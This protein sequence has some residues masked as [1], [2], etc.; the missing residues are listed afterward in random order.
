MIRILYILFASILFASCDHKEL[1]YDHSHIM[2]VD[3]TFDWSETPEASPKSMSLYLFP[4][5]DKEV[6][7]YEFTR[8]E[9][10]KIRIVPGTYRAICLNSDTENIRIQ[11]NHGFESFRLTTKDMEMLAGMTSLGVRSEDVPKIKGTEDER[12]A[13]SPD[14]IWTGSLYEMVLDSPDQTMTLTMQKRFSAFNIEVRNAENLQY[15]YAVS[16][17]L[18]TLSESLYPGEGVLSDSDVTIPFEMTADSK[19]GFIKGDFLTF[20]HCPAEDK[21]HYMTIYAIMSDGSKVYFTFDVTEQIHSSPD[22]S[23]IVIVLDGLQLPEPNLGEGGG[24]GG[25]RPEVN[26]WNQID[27]G[28]DM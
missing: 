15:A 9:G 18:T 26:G 28:I 22:D 10:G 6:Q 23:H 19:E 16:G 27:V 25:F 8:K 4:E 5:G 21:Q 24:G 17:C 12:T 7:R 3:V 1:C 20:G 14:S 11:D 13:M 2:E